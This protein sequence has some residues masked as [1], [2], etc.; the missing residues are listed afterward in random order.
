MTNE[1][2][3]I[4]R[5]HGCPCGYLGDPK[6]TCRCSPLQVQKYRNR[7]SG[8]LV[9]RIDIHVEVPAVAYRKLR[10][11]EPG[12][13]SAN[14]RQQVIA[15][16]KRQKQRFGCDSTATNARMSSRAIRKHCPLDDA[17]ESLLKQAMHELGLSA[18][19]HDKLLKLSR[20]IADLAEAENI[21]PEHLSEAIQY[22][23]LD[24]NV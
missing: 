10:S 5:T 8:P 14:I 1:Y 13:S 20:T 19:A 9:D 15:A 22:R 4:L 12:V 3:V 16:R 2:K 11:M 7:I 6:R 24:R 18:R 21:K 17:C 23:L